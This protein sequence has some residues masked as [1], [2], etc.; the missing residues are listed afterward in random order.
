MID[1]SIMIFLIFSSAVFSLI[2]RIPRIIRDF[3]FVSST[4]LTL[5]IVIINLCNPYTGFIFLNMFNLSI[6][7]NGFT[8]FLS[9]I[10]SFISFMVSIYSI[11]YIEDE[12]RGIYS[13]LVLIIV[14]CLIVMAFSWNLMVLFIFSEICIFASSLLVTHYK[15]SISY[16]AALKYLAVQF[17]SSILIL[18]G[19]GILYDEILKKGFYGFPVFDL[20][21]LSQYLEGNVAIKIG[22]IF[23]LIGFMAKL[24]LFPMHIW[25]PDASTV[26]PAP[27]SVLLH[28]MMIKVAG[29]PSFL[30]LFK[31]SNIFHNPIIL[32][33]LLCWL[34]IITMFVNTVMAF[35]QDDVKRLLAFDSVGQMGYV[36]LGL[37]IGGLGF[38]KF[39]IY[40][41][42]T[43]LEVAIIGLSSGL[44]HMF[45]HT[46]FKS[47]L[48][49]CSGNIEHET[50]I[51]DINR[52]GGLFNHMPFTSISMLIGSLA[53]SG[54]P[55]LN[56]FVSKWMIYNACIG[57]GEFI[58]AFISIFTCALTFA[59]FM[60]VI[61]SMCLGLS[62]FNKDVKEA[63]NIMIFPPILLSVFCIIFGIF[64]HIVL[65]YLLYPA[66]YSLTSIV[67]FPVID[68][69]ES[70][71]KLLYGFFDVYWL[72]SLFM[73]V[74]LLI[75]LIIHRFSQK[76]IPTV[77]RDKYLPFTGGV[78]QEPYI[79]INEIKVSSTPFTW[80]ILRFF[81]LFRMYHGGFINWY[82]LVILTFIVVIFTLTI[83]GG[84]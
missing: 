44:F 52:L 34:G 17:I 15:T 11:E 19:I 70:L 12:D 36:V 54:I 69:F 53:I 68:P 56:G 43:W 55:F 35:A 29:I 49:F 8:L 2:H 74:S 39:N 23:I 9:L 84:V 6:R 67:S 59:L 51:R 42:V 28:T 13:F 58:M 14:G 79:V 81:N 64:P 62:S 83:F 66:I 25:L 61:G 18:S 3:M 26:C 21:F 22:I 73:L 82:V 31:L 40:G 76:K 41:D 30:T 57:G 63:S 45:N 78:F 27:I 16:E 65:R 5:I 48:F 60:K 37:G 75:Y 10:V 1:P 77:S 71:I 32:W 38:M 80:F 47:V 46:L 4:L 7:V 33:F 24:P 50:G 20:D 72:F